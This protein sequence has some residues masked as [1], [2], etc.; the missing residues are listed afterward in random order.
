MEFDYTVHAEEII[1]ERKMS[2]KTIEE[3]VKD[4]ENVAEGR[5]G[6]K[7]AQRTLGKK[8]LRVIYS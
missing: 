1:M 6:R 8:L 5:F 7:I 4:A 2:K 3:V